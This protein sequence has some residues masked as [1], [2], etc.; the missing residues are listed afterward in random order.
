MV[1]MIRFIPLL[2]LSIPAAPAGADAKPR[3]A[4]CVVKSSGAQPYR[5]PCRFVAEEKGSFTVRPAGRRAFPGG[6]SAISVSI[7]SP[8]LAEV[9]GVTREGINSRW[10]EARRSRRDRACW[11]GADFS[12]CAY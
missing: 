9:R 8:G 3:G 10:G 1:G 6:V 5:G 11:T 12:V 2:I 4:Q 7:V